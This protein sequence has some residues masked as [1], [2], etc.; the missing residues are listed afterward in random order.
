MSLRG[1]RDWEDPAVE[2]RRL[3]AA[4][5]SFVHEFERYPVVAVFGVVAVELIDLDVAEAAGLI[6][7]PA[8]LERHL[9]HDAEHVPAGRLGEP[10]FAGFEAAKRAGR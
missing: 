3:P 6:D 10:D 9:V 4:P 1:L 7:V 2:A 5:K 8:D